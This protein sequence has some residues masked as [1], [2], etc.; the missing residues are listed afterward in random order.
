MAEHFKG[1]FILVP[2]APVTGLWCTGSWVA[3]S[4]GGKIGP[5]DEKG[6]H[7]SPE[8]QAVLIKHTEAA[9]AKAQET[10]VDLAKGLER[11]RTAPT[12]DWGKIEKKP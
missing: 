2:D 6:Y 3:I 8:T 11:L 9:L 4:Q 5:T 7:M 10:V 1:N 12:K